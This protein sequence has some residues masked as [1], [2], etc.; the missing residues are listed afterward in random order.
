M[1]AFMPMSVRKKRPSNWMSS[2]ASYARSRA[3]SNVD[4]TAVTASTR[5]PEVTS[6]PSSSSF[7][8]AW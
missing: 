8:P 4:A 1:I 7:V 5:P 3:A 6:V 2:A